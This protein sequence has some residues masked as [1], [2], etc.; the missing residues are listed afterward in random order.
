MWRPLRGPVKESPLA[1]LD[2][3]TTQKDDYMSAR[4]IFETR[5]AFD[6]ILKYNSGMSCPS[7]HDICG[8]SSGGSCK[9]LTQTVHDLS[10]L[11]VS[12]FCIKLGFYYASCAWN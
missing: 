1:L 10:G 5:F 12:D 2:V 7:V 9:N 3:K 4:C 11:Q 8:G 6:Y